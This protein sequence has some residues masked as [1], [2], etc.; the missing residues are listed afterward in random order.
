MQLNVSCMDTTQQ[1][2]LSEGNNANDSTVQWSIYSVHHTI[3]YSSTVSRIHI[4]YIPCVFS[5]KY[6]RIAGNFRGA[7]YSWFSTSWT[8]N[9][10]PTNK[11]TLLTFTCSASSNH[12]N[13]TTNG[14][15]LLN[16]EYF[17]PRKLPA[18][19]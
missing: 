15:I 10:L 11:A 16:H 14:L 1:T 7:K 2:S 12:E 3:I 5:R 6:Y 4:G 9:I 13:K 17:D 19:R 8:T 18:I